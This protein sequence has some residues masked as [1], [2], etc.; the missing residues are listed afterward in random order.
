M[1]FNARR[2]VHLAQLL[3]VINDGVAEIE[4]LHNG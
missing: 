1:R 4:R 2:Q 3:Q